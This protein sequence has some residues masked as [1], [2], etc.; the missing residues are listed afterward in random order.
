MFIVNTNSQPVQTIYVKATLSE[1]TSVL[2]AEAAALAL[3]ALITDKLGLRQVTFLSDNQQL[4]NFL[5]NQDQTNP[6]QWRIKYYTKI[7]CNSTA[8]RNTRTHRIHITQNQTADA[9]ARQALV[10]SQLPCSLGFI[11]TCT[12]AA[13]ERCTL[14]EALQF[15]TLNSVRLLTTSCC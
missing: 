14:Q 8:P 6:L 1:A 13:H 5:N 7:F 12:S 4:V 9:L 15:V 10:E 11:C 2:M 3:A